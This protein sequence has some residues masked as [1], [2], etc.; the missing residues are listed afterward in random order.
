MRSSNKDAFWDRLYDL[1]R[2][3]NWNELLKEIDNLNEKYYLFDEIVLDL[4]KYKNNI[5]DKIK[6]IDKKE[7]KHLKIL[8]NIKN[9]LWLEI[10][11]FSLEKDKDLKE[12]FILNINKKLN[13]KHTP[14]NKK[15]SLYDSLVFN[16]INKDFEI[17][18]FT[19]NPCNVGFWYKTNQIQKFLK[20]L[21]NK[22]FKDISTYKI[23]SLLAMEIYDKNF[24]NYFI[25]EYTSINEVI[26]KAEIML[27]IKN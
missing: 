13:D 7:D 12:F 17:N 15:I 11:D 3:Q 20:E 18:N 5:L 9:D 21:E 24:P 23:S 2:M 14:I 22:T 16:K 8:K 6:N 10:V 27:N 25:K 1:E 26:S 4:K 19:I